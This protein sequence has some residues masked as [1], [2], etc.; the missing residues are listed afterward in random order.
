LE[1]KRFKKG[2]SKV[3]CLGQIP[4]K[5]KKQQEKIFKNKN[6]K[7]RKH[8]RNNLKEKELKNIKLEK[9]GNLLQVVVLFVCPPPPTRTRT[10]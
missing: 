7:A 2:Q 9:L 8:N 5:P 6:L 3:F 10:Q 4:K 1:L